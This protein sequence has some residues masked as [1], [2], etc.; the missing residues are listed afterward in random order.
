MEQVLIMQDA[1]AFMDRVRRV[2]GAVG[3]ADVLVAEDG[4]RCEHFDAQRAR[5]AAG[6]VA[7]SG[8]RAAR[9]IDRRR[10]E[11]QRIAQLCAYYLV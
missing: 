5:R 8:I 2:Q 6:E 9:V 7:D 3:D 11:E 10:G 4:L 1:L